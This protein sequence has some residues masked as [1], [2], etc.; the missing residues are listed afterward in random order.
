[1]R[2]FFVTSFLRMTERAERPDVIRCHSERTVLPFEAQYSII[3]STLFAI[4]THFVILSVPVGSALGAQRRI[5]QSHVVILST[6]FVILSVSEES[7]S[8]S[9][10]VV[11]I[12]CMVKILRRYR[13]SE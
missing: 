5:L 6:H 4:S 8:T 2:R 12:L 3:L 10:K 7:L 1:M 13:S 11:C 9:D